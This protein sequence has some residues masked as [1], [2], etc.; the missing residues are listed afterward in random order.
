MST[1]LD[2]TQLPVEADA[3]LR[4]FFEGMSSFMMNS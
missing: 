1:A 4:Q 3:I 2:E